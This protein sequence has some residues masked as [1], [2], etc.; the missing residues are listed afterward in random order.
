MIEVREAPETPNR[1]FA[2]DLFA[3]TPEGAILARPAGQVRAGEEVAV[4][5]ALAGAEVPILRTLTG[6]AV[7]EGADL[8]WLDRATALLGIGLRT[9]I[10]AARRIGALLAE[11][12]TE[13]IAVDLPAGTMH[14]MGVLRI[15]DHDLAI[16]WPARTPFRAVEALRARGVRVVFLDGAALD[17]AEAGKALNFVT[18]GPR[19]I[20]MPAGAPAARRLYHTLGVE[21]VETAMTELAKAAGAV[22]CLTGVVAR[23]MAIEGGA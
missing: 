1:M 9:N 18:L 3:M 2:A 11:I 8:M 17:E 21:V 6:R 22:G 23:E 4:A 20:L 13:L 19:R 15:V 5:A 10:E 16:A 14:L 7:F 12:G